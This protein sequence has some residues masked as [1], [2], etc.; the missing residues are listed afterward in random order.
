MNKKVNVITTVSAWPEA[1]EVQRH[2]LD[3]Y[4]KDAFNFISVIDTSSNPNPWNLWDPELRQKAINIA[5]EYCD[6]VIM[7]P[8]ELHYDRQKLF[9]NTKVSK[10]KFSNERAADAL[11]FVFNARIQNSFNPC[12]ILDS[13]MFPI[14]PFSIIDSLVTTSIRGVLQNRNGRFNRQIE[15]YWNGILM[16]DPHRLKYLEDFSFDCGK[17]RG[18]KVDTG[19]QSY[20]WMKKMEDAGLHSELGFIKHFSSLNWSLNDFRGVIPSA[21]RRFLLGDDRNKFGKIYAEIYDETF[22]HFRAG[23]NWREEAIDV[24]QRRN[25]EF[26]KSCLDQ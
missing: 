20:W 26:I 8:E 18:L 10:A 25:R 16:F 3:R 4:S 2:L 14:A 11:Q 1:L 6:E 12:F 21:I 19:G 22:L 15:Y 13:D 23:S 17:V 7:M 9:P 24:V 5:H